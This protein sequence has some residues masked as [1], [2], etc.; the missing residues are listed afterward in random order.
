M[1]G[2]GEIQDLGEFGLGLAPKDSKPVNKIELTKKKE[3]EIADADRDQRSN[4][5]ADENCRP[6][7]LRIRSMTH[8]SAGAH[9]FAHSASWSWFVVDSTS[10][11]VPYRLNRLKAGGHARRAAPLRKQLIPS[12]QIP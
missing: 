9:L 8:R 1:A 7:D 5:V 10:R 2:V 11:I 4:D 3:A 12:G 6:G